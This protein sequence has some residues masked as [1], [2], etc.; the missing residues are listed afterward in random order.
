[1]HDRAAEPPLPV[2]AATLVGA[3]AVGSA[4]YLWALFR[5]LTRTLATFGRPEGRAVVRRVTYQQVLFTGAEAVPVVVAVASMLGAAI[6]LQTL[7]YLSGAEAQSVLGPVM[8]LVVFRELGPLMTLLV[9]IG[10]SGGAITVE[11]G[12]MRVAGEI[13]L[14][15]GLGIDVARYVVLPRVVGVVLSAMT[16]AVVFDVASATSGFLAAWALIST[17]PSVF[18][19][20]ASRH[21][22]FTDLVVTMLKTVSC[23]LIVA[24]ISTYEGL[25]ASSVTEVPQ[26]TRRGMVN[27]LVACISTSLVISFLFY[28]HGLG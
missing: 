17:P 4:R 7:S 9:I 11:L 24:T 20:F 23:S 27:G 21:T 5:H 15:E 22:A 16:L 2:R 13:E 3:P 25:S 8:Q 6:T 12:N 1:M 18:L 14:L 19:E 28:A 26:A 10:R